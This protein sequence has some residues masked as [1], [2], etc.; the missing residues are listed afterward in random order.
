[1]DGRAPSHHAAPSEGQTPPRDMMIIQEGKAESSKGKSLWNPS[2]NVPTYL[3]KALLPNE[4]RERLMGYDENHLVREAIKQFGQ[5]FT[6][7]CLPL[8][9]KKNRRVAEELKAQENVELRKEV[10]CLQNEL[11]HSKGLQ[12][13][14][15]RLLADKA[16][17]ATKQTQEVARLTEERASSC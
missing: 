13:E 15:E 2:L 8:T 6:T 12:Q 10:E 11:K 9:R 5:A 7:S 17:K 1:L 3:E 4:D 16:K 14:N